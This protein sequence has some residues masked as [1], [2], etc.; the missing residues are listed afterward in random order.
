MSKNKI[1][2]NIYSLSLAEFATKGL[3]FFINAYLARILGV[4]GYGTVATINSILVYFLIFVNL[5]FHTVGIRTIAQMMGIDAN[6]IDKN[7]D[8]IK[9]NCEKIQVKNRHSSDYINNVITLR[10]M[11]AII[12]YGGLLVY[13]LFIND[14]SL[15][16]IALIIGGLQFFAEAFGLVWFYIGVERMEIV[17]LRHTLVSA[18]TLVCLFL[19]VKSPEDI[20]IYILIVSIS[21]LLNNLWLVIMYAK[22]YAKIKLQIQLEYWKKLLK[23]SSTVA[24]PSLIMAVMTT[25]SILFLARFVG[26]YET[27]LFSA[28]FKLL[29]FCYIP[30][31]V[32]QVSFSPTISKATTLKE[33]IEATSKYSKIIAILGSIV[34]TVILFFPDVCTV[35]VSGDKFLGSIPILQILMINCFVGYYNLSVAPVLLFWKLEK[36]SV[37]AYSIA[38]LACIGL[39][40]LLIQLFTVGDIGDKYWNGGVGAAFATLGAELVLAISVSYFFFKEIKKLYLSIFLKLIALGLLSGF[41]GKSVLHLANLHD[42]YFQFIGILI[43]LISFIFLILRF[44]IIDLRDIKKLI[45]KSTNDK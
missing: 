29:T 3:V 17:A 15:I 41:I 43:T 14:S 39:N 4:E 9:K 16:K 25:F 38:V 21:I 11:L 36:K 24:I 12:S 22:Q 26:E 37:Y 32:I 5:G 1:L 34:A 40:I 6:D 42:I 18:V 31:F 2:K 7:D 28:A 8:D 33:R 35:I 20:P 19:F 10:I 23:E 44:K 27:G 13:A 30:A 45:G